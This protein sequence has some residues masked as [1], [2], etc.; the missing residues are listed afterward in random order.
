MH[1]R[2]STFFCYSS[3]TRYIHHIYDMTRHSFAGFRGLELGFGHGMGMG[4]HG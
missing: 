1:I 4:M 2:H 3:G